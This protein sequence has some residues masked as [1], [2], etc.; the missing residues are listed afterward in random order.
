[1]CISIN[2]SFMALR[3]IKSVFGG[4]FNIL[5]WIGSVLCFIA[6]GI[7]QSDI[8]DPTNVN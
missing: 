7:D 3:L 8:K 4:F 1:M 5:L 6:Y 2:Y